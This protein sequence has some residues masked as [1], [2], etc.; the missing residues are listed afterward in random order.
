MKRRCVKEVRVGP[1]RVIES[2]AQGELKRADLVALVNTIVL[3]AI[4]EVEEAE[5]STKQAVE[6]A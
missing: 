3:Q 6:G 1:H 2:T 4:R 5:R